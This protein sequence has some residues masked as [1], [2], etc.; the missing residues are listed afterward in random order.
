MAKLPLDLS[1]FK[2]IASD[3]QSTT[4]LH[5]DGHQIKLAL[6]A[7]PHKM[8]EQLAALPVHKAEGGYIPGEGAVARSAREQAAREAAPGYENTGDAIRGSEAPLTRD[9]PAPKETHQQKMEALQRGAG[10]G[11]GVPDKKNYAEG[12]GVNSSSVQDSP[13]QIQSDMAAQPQQAPV[14]VNVNGGQQQQPSAEAPNVP[15]LVGQHVGEALK[16]ALPA[17]VQLTKDSILN[18]PAGQGFQLAQG[19]AKGVQPQPEAAPQPA[20]QPGVAPSTPAPDMAAP[21]GGPPMGTPG[22]QP[23]SD[24][25][26]AMGAGMDTLFGGARQQIAGIQQEAAA[27]A[28]LGDQ[29]A[30]A[31]AKQAQDL[32]DL[33][34]NIQDQQ[35]WTMHEAQGAINDIAN[36]HIDYN[37][38]VGNMS[39]GKR[40]ATAIGMAFGGASQALNG[41]PNIAYEALKD[42]INRDIQT[43]QAQLGQKQTLFSAYMNKFKN[44]N[45]AASMA[46]TVMGLQTIAQINQYAAKAQGPLAAAMAKRLTGGI[47]TDMISPNIQK[48]AMN[49]VMMGAS[50]S[51]NT[52]RFMQVMQWANPEQYKLYADKYVPGVG[53]A[54]VPVPAAVRDNL[55]AKQTLNDAAQRMYQ[56]SQA[57]SGDLSPTDK[58][59][60]ATMAAELQS[61]YRNAI[62]GGVFKKGEQEF[63]DQII[64]SNPTKFFN[65][66]R[67]LPKLKQV[68]DSN[69]MQANTLKK[70]Y[71]LPTPATIQALPPK[72]GKK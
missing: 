12:G 39:F 51:G 65:S 21:P 18:S 64:D 26:N 55:V 54:S 1:K 53:M 62:N 37:R 20:E 13:E 36:Q 72:L 17:V 23:P 16:N 40:I 46:A 61:M 35:N 33:N 66:I 5:N 71:G 48:L 19:I 70:S 29:Q 7:L 25:L 52:D 67:V 63:I 8:R 59:V 22:Q 6:N 69:Q 10:F 31:Y 34:T 60:G 2:K 14:V 56:W 30:Q 43:Q 41:G 50:Q 28:K 15:Q 4:L 42:N 57:H 38:Y 24:P 58:A 49:Q 68:I 45:D 11:T 3:K 27:K 47:Y 44:A 9:T 32:S